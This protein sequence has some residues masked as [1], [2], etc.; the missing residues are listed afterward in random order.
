M[1]PWN[2]AGESQK[3]RAF[4]L[5]TTLKAMKRSV[6]S[7]FLQGGLSFKGVL[8]DGAMV[9]PVRFTLETLLFTLRQ[10][11]GNCPKKVAA[12]TVDRAGYMHGY[13]KQ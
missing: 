3:S 12:V 9:S 8:T 2:A 4:E 10:G 6:Q 7:I 11:M 1:S 13:I 5:R